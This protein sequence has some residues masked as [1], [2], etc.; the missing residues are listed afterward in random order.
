MKTVP[1]IT[2]TSSSMKRRLRRRREC[3]LRRDSWPQGVADP[4]HPIFTN[5]NPQLSIPSIVPVEAAKQVA[6]ELGLVQSIAPGVGLP[7]TFKTYVTAA[8]ADNTRRAYQGDL[9]D[10]VRWGGMVPC[11]TET[12]AAYIA[13]RA[14]TL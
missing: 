4:T 13:D 14:E 2:P 7:E 10:F 5:D 3:A 8:L 11:S 6:H 1:Q 9:A 12:L